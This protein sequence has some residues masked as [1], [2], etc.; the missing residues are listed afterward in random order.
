MIYVLEDDESIRELV[1]YSIENTI[2]DCKGFELPSQFYK[3]LKNELPDLILLDIMLPEENGMEVLKKLK[4]SG[5]TDHI[6]IIMLTAKSEEIDKVMGLDN[7]AEDYITKPF[8]MM[9]LLARVKAVLRRVKKDENTIV[10]KDLVLDKKAVTVK[11]KDE[12]I[13]LRLK[14]FELLKILLINKNQVFT[15]N[16]LLDMVWEYDLE[17]QTRTVDVHI[18]SLRQK[19]GE[20]GKYIKTIRGMGYKFSEDKYD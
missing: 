8:G 6:P 12:N 9:E 15:R 11:I 18:G 16:R 13:D 19:L 10:F 5:K 1:V 2:G 20:Y 4:S 17:V 3:T 7:G 14:E